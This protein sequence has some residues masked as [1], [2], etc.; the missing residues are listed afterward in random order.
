[1]II[2]IAWRNVWRSK[3]R[4]LVI[5]I[6]I[7]LGI[8]AGVF[9]TAFM[10]GMSEQRIETAIQTETSHIQIHQKEYRQQDKLNLYLACADE[11]SDQVKSNP[12]VQG[13][14]NR[15]ILNGMISSAGKGSGARVMGINPEEEKTV[16]DLHTR[17]I[18]GSYF[19][20]VPH[21][22][23][24]LIIGQKMAEKLNVRL[25]SRI[26][27]NFTNAQ[28]VPTSIG[29]RVTGIY[30]TVNNNFDGLNVYTRY[31]D[32]ISNIGLPEGSGHEIAILL[33]ENGI[34]E[35]VKSQLQDQFPTTEISSWKDLSPE[36]TYLHEMMDQYTYI[37]ILIILLA[38]LFGIINT[39]LMA[40]LERIKELGMLM[41]IGMSKIR[42][43][44]MIMMESIF[45]SFTGGVSGVIL[46][47]LATTTLGNT[48]I[49]MSQYSEGLQAMGWSSIIY[50]AIDLTTL[51]HITLM[52][53]VTG[54]IS[55]VY[56]S[57]KALKLNPAESIRTE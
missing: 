39:M 32:L 53:I 10:K 40:V 14:S 24:P 50:P 41:A 56:P 11:L 46:G 15:V 7:T 37:I 34:S 30:K 9:S 3:I 1:M 8:C 20:D 19:Q 2:E 33:K 6:A 49:D 26:V 57:L 51:L 13:V 21:R 42:I 28:G 45:L 55:A 18:E 36:L 16:T 27:I 48:G 43:F 4:S 35:E 52:V 54:I 12:H 44:M 23:K 17:I 38:L 29:F 31:T 22:V 5:I 25:R 47:Y